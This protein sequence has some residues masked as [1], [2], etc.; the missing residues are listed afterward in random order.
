MVTST[1]PIVMTLRST[2]LA[3][4]TLLGT[5]IL[6]ST[7]TATMQITFPS[8]ATG[9]TRLGYPLK[10]LQLALDK[11]GVDYTLVA[12]PRPDSNKRV[13]LLMKE[14]GAYDVAF[15]GTRPE[16]ENTLR[17]IRFPIHRGLLGNRVAITHRDNLDRFDSFDSLEDFRS[18]S[19]CQGLGWSDTQILESVGLNVVTGAYANLFQMAN[20]NRC[21]VY[22]RAVFEAY[23]E[24][25]ERS[26]QL[27]NLTVDD[28]ILIR[29]RL[30]SF[31]FV[32]PEREE[33]AQA[34]EAGLEIAMQDGS[35]RTLFEAEPIHRIAKEN[36]GQTARN[37][38]EIK[39]P[40]L[41]EETAAIPD[42]Y[43]NGFDFEA[44]TAARGCTL[45]GTLS[46]E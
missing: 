43:W 22:T 41:T 25:D 36:L 14:E 11:A 38:I 8:N 29:Y 17:P 16:L 12:K 18:L 33:L 45:V 44:E 15:F 37:C 21:D 32:N 42:K 24:V 9:D 10:L 46:S 31:I 3:A 40:F 35:F 7:A 39:N 34:I 26:G 19:I 20:A 1:E 30:A 4:A 13:A 23:H 2:L 27:P 6:P 28:S 5:A